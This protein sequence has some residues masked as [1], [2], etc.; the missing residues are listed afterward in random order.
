M[1]GLP[2]TLLGGLA[3][4]IIEMRINDNIKSAKA[5]YEQA[6]TRDLSKDEPTIRQ[7]PDLRT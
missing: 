2:F 3:S 1:L 6:K 5:Q 4:R 7:P